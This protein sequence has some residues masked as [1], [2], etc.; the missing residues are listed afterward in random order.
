MPWLARTCV[1]HLLAASLLV[2]CGDDATPDADA[3]TGVPDGGGDA[4]G[5]VECTLTP[6]EICA[7]AAAECG[8]VSTD[9]CP[10]MPSVDCGGCTFPDACLSDRTCGA[11]SGW[12]ALDGSDFGPW[13]EV[14]TWHTA[15]GEGLPEGQQLSGGNYDAAI[16]ADGTIY[17]VYTTELSGPRLMAH[18]GTA[19]RDYGTP[20]GGDLNLLELDSMDRPVVGVVSGADLSVWR[21]EGASWVE[22]ADTFTASDGYVHDL[23]LDSADRPVALYGA[24]YATRVVLYVSRW[25]GAAWQPVGGE[26]RVSRTDHV[27]RGARL[28]MRSDDNPSVVYEHGPLTALTHTPRAAYFDGTVWVSEEVPLAAPNDPRATGRRTLAVDET[29][30]S[31]FGYLDSTAT[32]S[33]PAVTRW[34]GSTWGLV[35]DGW[36]G[37]GGGSPPSLASDGMEGVLA[38][39]SRP[40]PSGTETIVQ[41]LT[42]GAWARVGDTV[43]EAAIAPTRQVLAAQGDQAVFVWDSSIAGLWLTRFVDGAWQPLGS[44]S[45]SGGALSDTPS[46]SGS[47]QLAANAA[48]FPIVAWRDDRSVFIE[49]FDGSSWVEMGPGSAAGD[50]LLGSA[51]R[52]SLTV[53]GM[54]RAIVARD[55]DDQIFVSRFEDGAWAD[56]GPQPVADGVASCVSGSPFLSAHAERVVMTWCENGSVYVLGYDD[57]TGWVEVGTGS[58]S[59]EGV[60][61]PNRRPMGLTHDGTG[62]PVILWASFADEYWVARFDGVDWVVY[63][64]APITPGGNWASVVLDAEGRPVVPFATNDTVG[65]IRYD[66]TAWTAPTTIAASPRDRPVVTVDGDGTPVVAWLDR[67]DGYPQT[68]LRR[69]TATGWEEHVGSATDGGISNTRAA[70]YQPAVMASADLLCAAW[71]EVGDGNREVVLRCALP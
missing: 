59:D 63:G 64:D 67:T 41:K 35:S 37:E 51:Q 1:F 52:F 49:E 3:G 70:L 20:A 71:S 30:A 24:A 33:P 40:T 17:V 32:G 68:Y 39:F 4:D 8:T 42:G 27:L 36:L 18:D 56:L 9:A 6:E 48:G 62:A 14:M 61:G 69:L 45:A 47:V 34:D 38:A 2:G 21:L 15:G 5:G 65:A 60:S 28:A 13:E 10:A 7:A 23:V 54:G 44:G 53:D 58:A 16:A 66:G 29:D 46:E 11:P 12:F 57:A 25:D 19:L 50:G 26:I 22:A 55:D 43:T 31:L